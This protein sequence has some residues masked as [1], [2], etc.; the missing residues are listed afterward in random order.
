MA[1]LTV[2]DITFEQ[3]LYSLTTTET[4]QLLL[5]NDFI[6]TSK[7]GT[8]T[9][10]GVKTV[11]QNEITNKRFKH[12]DIEDLT[13]DGIMQV[14]YTM[15]STSDSDTAAVISFLTAHPT[16]I[17]ATIGTNFAL[18]KS[19]IVTDTVLDRINNDDFGSVTSNRKRFYAYTW[20]NNLQATI[21]DPDVDNLISKQD[22]LAS[23]VGRII[24]Y[25]TPSLSFTQP[26]DT[27]TSPAAIWD[28]IKTE[29]LGHRVVYPLFS[30]TM[31]QRPCQQLLFSA[32]PS[33]GT[34][35]LTY[36]GNTTATIN[37]NDSRT[38]VISKVQSM[39]SV[40]EP[41]TIVDVVPFTASSANTYFVTDYAG[42]YQHWGFRI[43]FYP[44]NPAPYAE[45]GLKTLMTVTNSLNVSA[46]MSATF[47][48]H[49]FDA[50]DE[51]GALFKTPTTSV[52]FDGP[53]RTK[54][55]THMAA[56][57]TAW[58][59]AFAALPVDPVYGPPTIDYVMIDQESESLYPFYTF[60]LDFTRTGD[61]SYQDES[62]KAIGADPRFA[63]DLAPRLG[64]F[65]AKDVTNIGSYAS[66][67]PRFWDGDVSGAYYNGYDMEKI[68][69]HY[70]WDS[71]DIDRLA[72]H[73]H[74]CVYLPCKAVYPNVMGSNYA[75]YP[76]SISYRFSNLEDR[77]KFWSMGGFTGTSASSYFYGEELS[78]NLTIDELPSQTQ[79]PDSNPRSTTDPLS[80]IKIKH[81]VRS[82]GVVT[83]SIFN[84]ND[85]DDGTAAR[86]R[87]NKQFLTNLQVGDQFTINGVING[88]NNTNSTLVGA[89]DARFAPATAFNFIGY[90][91][92]VDLFTITSITNDPVTDEPTILTYNDDRADQTYAPSGS[93]ST[94][95]LSSSPT[96]NQVQ[97]NTSTNLVSTYGWVSGTTVIT[98]EVKDVVGCPEANGLFLGYINGNNSFRL[99]NFSLQA[100]TSSTTGT[101]GTWAVVTD[102]LGGGLPP[103][104]STY[105][106]WRN[107]N[108][109]IRKLRSIFVPAH[110]PLNMWITTKFYHGYP[111]YKESDLYQEQ[112][113][114]ILLHS[115]DFRLLYY[116]E[117]ET[118]RTYTYDKL[119]SNILK[120]ADELFG[121]DDIKPLPVNYKNITLRESYILSGVQ[122][123]GKKIYRF[124]PQFGSEA[125]Q[126]EDPID[127]TMDNVVI[128]AANPV[129][130]QIND[131]NIVVI[132]NASIVTP[133]VTNSTRG[134]WIQQNPSSSSSGGDGG[135]GGDGED[136]EGPTPTPGPTDDG[137]ITSSATASGFGCD[138]ENQYRGVPVGPGCQKGNR[139]CS[140]TNGALVPAITVC[141][142][143]DYFQSI[144]PNTT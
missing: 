137:S 47:T 87:G 30:A 35:T 125:R 74:E 105:D 10:A 58:F 84:S 128:S 78:T 77:N 50:L 16:T 21:D 66:N 28:K 8:S 51:S 24:Q 54:Y 117:N 129:A 94:T 55:K 29:P 25:K 134:L 23:G 36:N 9:A 15:V 22:S 63:T 70:V 118:F 112:L 42:N 48:T 37:W 110:I 104:I 86:K 83:L 7:T 141:T 59:E 45:A 19:T 88:Q 46:T 127:V 31:M 119:V 107:F 133:S 56:L 121:Y 100:V 82:N 111:E 27:L 11:I 39:V 123:H 5:D 93:V 138:D 103:H 40:S 49:P 1:T 122:C 97:I 114:H 13:I 12:W 143:R 101:G 2:K 71:V 102:G 142:A 116:Q 79:E 61:T 113:Y 89:I 43:Y 57:Y 64:N 68:K 90:L 106:S 98:V 67:S 65:V 96:A 109:A 92:M 132:Q 3:A 69:K 41:T 60:K 124:T 73:L 144:Q 33:S 26:V 115:R 52:P 131:G 18:D 108:V 34:Y 95:S 130:L 139:T 135:D 99:V 20:R 91:K 62:W 6:D 32:I 4:I 17:K 44:T 120:E 140:S 85:I 75:S 14:L 38:T 72:E 76:N 81:M 53:Y 80:R 136:G 126:V